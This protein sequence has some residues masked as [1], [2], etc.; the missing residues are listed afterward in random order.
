MLSQ[1][2]TSETFPPASWSVYNQFT[3]SNN[4]HEGWHNKLKNAADRKVRL[5][6]YRLV[7][8]LHDEAREVPLTA[9]LLCQNLLREHTSSAHI[10][11]VGRF[12]VPRRLLCHK[13]T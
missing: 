7:E 9:A 8:L 6:L 1:W 2:I 11:L 13:P 5:N 4:A 10:P 3:R 12:V